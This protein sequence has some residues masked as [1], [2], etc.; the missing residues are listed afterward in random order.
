MSTSTCRVVL[1]LSVVLA[2]PAAAG[3]QVQ[4]ITGPEREMIQMP[5]MSRQNKTG[6]GRIRG[7]VL[8]ADSG[9]PLRR[10]QI[11][12]SSPDILPKAA[13]TDGE[14]RYEFRDLPA[15]RFTLQ[16][17]KSGY[18]TVQYGQTR[19]FESGKPIELADKQA[20]DNADISMPRGSVISGRILDEFGD[21]VPD[22][23]V[24]AMRQSWVSG[25]RRLSA[26]GGRLAQTND[27]G[28]Y[29]IYGL[30]PGEY[31][32]SATLRTGMEMMAFDMLGAD[33]GAR[34]P[35]G[36]NPSSGYAPTYFPGTVNAA[37]AQRVPVAIGQEA[38]S[39]DF[40]LTPV[41]L[42]R[43]SGQVISSEGKPLEGAMI[44]VLPQMRNELSIMPMSGT[45]RT[46][47]DGTF[48]INGVAPGDYTLQA[49]SMQVFT[50]SEGGATMVF[51]AQVGGSG[52][53]GSE[54][55]SMPLSVAGEDVPNL[56]MVTSKGGSASGRVTF[57]GPRPQNTTGIRITAM[58]ADVEGP[59]LAGGGAGSVTADGTFEL[60]G[61]A[62][63]RIIRAAGLPPG[64]SLKAVRLNGN[65]ITDAGADFKGGESVSGLEV[66]LTSKTTTVSGG[67][68]ADDGSPLKD[69][70]VVIFSEDPDQWRAPM[71]RWVVGT[72]PD[73]DG[74]FKVENLPSGSY[75][76]VA[77]DY[78]PQGEWGDPDL[79]DRL[80]LK[81]K[82][83]TLDE[84]QATTLDLKLSDTY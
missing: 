71:S 60:K 4:I 16:A 20:L 76:A 41:R 73:Q 55:G 27:L 35:S 39:T 80:K 38:Q 50:S 37:E 31:Y 79:L 56:V 75:Y 17:T 30:P 22:V 81:A 5:G 40:A 25:R 36:S 14:G 21:P 84:G 65:D 44:S 33:A 74:R 6:T 83:F 12:I 67:V 15:G 32:V 61:L 51:R 42:A 45:S 62:G 1:V 18:V 19:P 53:G 3:A 66:V 13:M 46:G 82:R 2:A 64:W 11:R 70:T 72:R 26:V 10:A 9:N 34:G 57:D 78:L 77:V 59:M 23:S 54:F 58:S 68:A 24:T 52:D 7:R 47:K 29:R 49:R 63:L 48:T 69:Y 28:Q 43:I 8:A